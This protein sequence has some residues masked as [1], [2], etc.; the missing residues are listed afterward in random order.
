MTY[1]KCLL[2][3]GELVDHAQN[4]VRSTRAITAI[5]NS[6]S[7]GHLSIKRSALSAV[8]LQRRMK[9]NQRG[10]ESKTRLS[11]TEGNPL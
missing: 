11:G 9:E 6:V 1:P 4:G 8:A 7:Q 2:F 10:D 5:V 3:A